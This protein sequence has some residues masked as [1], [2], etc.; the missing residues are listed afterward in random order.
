M[1]CD[2]VNLKIIENYPLS[3]TIFIHKTIEPL[4]EENYL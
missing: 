1:S 3:I 4:G 2:N